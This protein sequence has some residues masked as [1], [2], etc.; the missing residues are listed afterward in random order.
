MCKGGKDI[1][2]KCGEPNILVESLMSS[3]GIEPN[4]M[5]MSEGLS[6]TLSPN[7]NPNPDIVYWLV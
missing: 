4:M 6:T 3:N 7:P 1:D 5:S 2:P